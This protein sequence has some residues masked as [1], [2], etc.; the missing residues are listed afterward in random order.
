MEK[1]NK[2]DVLITPCSTPNQ[3]RKD[4]NRRR[5]NLFTPNKKEDKQNKLNDMGIGRSIPIKQVTI[6]FACEIWFDLNWR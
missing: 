4:T 1:A 2:L 5:S 6:L 3:K